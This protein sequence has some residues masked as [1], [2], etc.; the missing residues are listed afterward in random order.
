MVAVQRSAVTR[1][2]VDLPTHGPYRLAM[3]TRA[4]LLVSLILPGCYEAHGATR[5]SD[6]HG[7]PCECSSCHEGGADGTLR[8]FEEIPVECA[9]LR[10][11]FD[12][13]RAADAAVSDA[14]R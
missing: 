5:S 13:T 7:G 11:W 4:L 3:N 9:D 1:G 12:Q 10:Q 8:P 2:A 14:G 6:P